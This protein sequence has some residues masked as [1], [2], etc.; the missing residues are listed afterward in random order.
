MKSLSKIFLL[1]CTFFP[2][3]YM[4]YFL[5]FLFRFIEAST[6][7]ESDAVFQGIFGLHIAFMIFSVALVGF[8]IVHAMRNRA[9]SDTRKLIWIILFIFGAMISMPVYWYLHIWKVPSAYVISA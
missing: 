6:I 8:Y 4:V 7:E 1:L 5:G 2:W 3:A 9:L